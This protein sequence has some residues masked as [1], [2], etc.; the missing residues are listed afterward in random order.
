MITLLALL[1]PPA[2]VEPAAAPPAD[3]IAMWVWFVVAAI[4]IALLYG[5]WKFWQ[6][7]QKKHHGG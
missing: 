5:C 4:A 1:T 3:T 6:A 2:P 7:H